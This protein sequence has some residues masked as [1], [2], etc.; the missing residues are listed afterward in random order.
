MPLSH[1]IS[2]SEAAHIH[3]RMPSHTVLTLHRA[4]ARRCMRTE[5]LSRLLA[6]DRALARR[7]MRTVRLSRLPAQ[8]VLVPGTWQPLML[9]KASCPERSESESASL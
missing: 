6:Q 1:R 8:D 7:C 4:L 2:F 5:R 9:N 3:A